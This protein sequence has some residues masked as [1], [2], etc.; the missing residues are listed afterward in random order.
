MQAGESDSGPSL[1]EL[2]A[3]IPFAVELG[4]GLEATSSEDVVGRLRWRRELHDSRRRGPG[5]DRTVAAQAASGI[6]PRG[7]DPDGGR[8]NQC[9]DLRVG[10][11]SV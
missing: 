10:R 11:R 4:M 1:S 6:T 2:T 8:V 7:K 3:V 9:D 5:G